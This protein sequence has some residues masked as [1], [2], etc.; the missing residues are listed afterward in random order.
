MSLADRAMTPIPAVLNNSLTCHV[1]TWYWAAEEAAA[2][3]LT[4]A[5]A[6]LVRAINIARMAGTPQGAMLGLRTVGRWN[7]Q[8][9]GM[10]GPGMV[11]L[12]AFGS[13]HSAIS[14][15]GGITG[16]NQPCIFVPFITALGYTQ[17]LPSQLIANALT[18]VLIAPDTVIQAAA[19]ANL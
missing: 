14:T 10:P 1:A 18:C 12:W 11:M 5:K 16:Y 15:P 13:T 2:R 17:G 8:T 6:P 7:F 4:T 9:Q 19:A 3:G